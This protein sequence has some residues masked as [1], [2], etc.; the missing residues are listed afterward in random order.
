MQDPRLLIHAYI[1]GVIDDA[2]FEAL[3]RWLGESAENRRVFARLMSDHAAITDWSSELAGGAL[4]PE[5]STLEEPEIER[6][7][8]I[9]LLSALDS[10]PGQAEIVELV[11]TTAPAGLGRI[12]EHRAAIVWGGAGLAAAMLLFGLLLVISQTGPT[13]IPSAPPIAQRPPATS[14]T[15]TTTPQSAK[16]QTAKTQTAKTQAVATLTATHRAQWLGPAFSVGDELEPGERLQLL[17]GFA[18]ITTSRGAVAILQ[19]PITIELTDS[20][21]AL[22]LHEGRLVGICRTESSKGFTVETDYC[23]VVD[24][25]TEFGVR[26]SPAGVEATV[27]VGEIAMQR[28]NERTTLV[29]QNQTARLPS[30]GQSQVIV[31]EDQV[32]QGYTHWRPRPAIVISA[33]INDDR[34]KLEIAPQG[35]YEDALIYSDRDYQINSLD[36]KGLPVELLRGDLIRMPADARLGRTRDIGELHVEVELSQRCDIYLIAASNQGTLDWVKRDYELTSMRVGLDQ[37]DSFEREPVPEGLGVGPGAS[38]DET[39][40]VWKRKQPAT[41]RV[42][43]GSAHD[44]SMYSIVAVPTGKTAF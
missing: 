16:T 29:T 17:A 3:C 43:F 34:F 21:N 18:E 22:R 19:A 24:I 30:D 41:G 5:L 10:K 35:V 1:D 9:K 20:D 26:L 25:G 38:I 12:V 27:F 33:T 44:Q 2:G 15:Q 14:S 40:S 28:P 42:S 37:S 13:T 32:A 11:D 7:E 39:Y 31:V 4:V 23:K 8:W 6:S 36:A